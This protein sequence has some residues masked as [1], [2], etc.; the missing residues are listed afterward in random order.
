MLIETS[1]GQKTAFDGNICTSDKL[2][3]P[4]KALCKGAIAKINDG[5][6]SNMIGIHNRIKN[7]SDVNQILPILDSDLTLL[8]IGLLKDG[9]TLNKNYSGGWDGESAQNGDDAFLLSTTLN[10]NLNGIICPDGKQCLYSISVNKLGNLDA[11]PLSN[12][13]FNTDTSD[14]EISNGEQN[15][16]WVNDD[17]IVIKEAAQISIIDRNNNNA[18]TTILNNQEIDTINLSSD[19]QLYI[20][21]TTS[22]GQHKNYIYNIK[23]KKGLE[24]PISLDELHAFKAL[25]PVAED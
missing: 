25:V 11:S 2:S 18:V 12:S 13:G 6:L 24:S 14:D 15:D 21:S 8:N 20:T 7:L 9:D 23:T 22:S 4:Q 10:N 1:K 16:L 17:Y 5:L 3:L 19:N